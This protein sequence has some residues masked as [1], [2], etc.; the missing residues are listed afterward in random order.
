MSGAN[1]LK[2]GLLHGDL[3]LN[4]DSEDEGEICIGCAGG[5]DV[6]VRLPYKEGPAPAGS[7]AFKVDVT[8]LKG[9]HSG[10]DIHLGR[11]NAIKLLA[12]AT[13]LALQQK[14]FFV[15]GEGR[16][17]SNEGEFIVTTWEGLVYTLRFGLKEG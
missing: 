6:K 9:G 11:A 14:G 3:L 7:V 12:R 4:L 10:V 13:L 15:T 5:V 8:G 1:G 2:E 17:V 16:L